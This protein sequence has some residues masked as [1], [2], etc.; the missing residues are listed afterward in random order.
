MNLVSFNE[1]AGVP[2]YYDR[3]PVAEYG[4]KGKGPRVVRLDSQFKK[5]LEACLYE[6][7]DAFPQGK[8]SHFVTAGFYVEKAGPHA[9]GRA[10]D[11]DGLWWDGHPPIVAKNAPNDL[12]RY[13]G[14]EAVI[15]KHFGV[16]LDYWYNAKHRDHWHIDDTNNILPFTFK[17]S[18][19]VF[20][21]ACL[22]YLGHYVDIDGCFGVKTSE[23]YDSV[24]SVR[25]DSLLNDWLIFLN[26]MIYK[27][28]KM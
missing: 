26:F 5:K 4:S 28:L 18:H 12:R 11:I 23:L 25:K 27:T 7:W 2:I 16:V 17:R 14:I 21:Q 1:I 24:I 10:V 15:R 6:L 3:A 13:L 20:I 9:S 8:A 22:Q 19:T